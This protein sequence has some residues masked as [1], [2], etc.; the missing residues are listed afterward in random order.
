MIL[1]STQTYAIFNIKKENC[2][3]LP[4]IC[5]YGIFSKGLK[6]EFEKAISAPATEVLLY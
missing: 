3:K 6:N 2:P 1:M 4:Q 5:S